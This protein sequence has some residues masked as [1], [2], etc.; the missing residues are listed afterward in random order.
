MGT[1]QKKKTS[2]GKIAL[3][4]IAALFLLAAGFYS[5]MLALAP[6]QKLAEIRKEYS[7]KK[8]EYAVDEKFRNDT[9]FLR[10]IKEKA[11][12]Q[13][14]IAMAETDSIYLTINL[15][16]STANLEISGVVVHTA[17]ISKYSGS[18]ILLKHDDNSVVAMLAAPLTILRSTATIKK[19]PLMVKMA[20]KDTSEYKPDIMPDT[21]RVENVYYI[22]EMNNGLRIF[23]YQKEDDRK[24]S[25]MSGL[26][27]DLT[28]RLDNTLKDFKSISDFKVPKYHPYIRIVLPRADAKIIYRA[29]PRHGQIGIY[30]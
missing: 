27:F 4:V 12:L 15:S 5:A 25:G 22:L 19:E 26:Q 1:D 23:V 8:S 21:S 2:G 17:K 30:I 11:F 6:G 14:R 10:L 13:S 7:R 29:I 18:S 16:D 3:I 20:P 9:A 28:D 24:D